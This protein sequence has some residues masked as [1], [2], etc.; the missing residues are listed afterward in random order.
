MLS[1]NPTFS[2][3][4]VL[5]FPKCYIVGIMQYVVFSDW[6]LSVSNVHLLFIHSFSWLDS[7]CLLMLNHILLFGHTTVYLS[8]CLLKDILV[9]SKS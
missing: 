9:A 8:I 2:D 6:L 7:S 1:F 4:I 5:P 3:S